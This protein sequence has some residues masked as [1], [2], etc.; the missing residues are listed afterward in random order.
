MATFKGL[1]FSVDNV[2]GATF[3]LILGGI[4]AS[5]DVTTSTGTVETLFTEVNRLDEAIYVGIKTGTKP[6]AID[7]TF[8]S[9]NGEID[10]QKLSHI[11]RSLFNNNK[12]VKLRILQTDLN[13]ITY[14]GVFEECNPRA[15][16]NGIFGI[17]CKFQLLSNYAYEGKKTKALGNTFYNSSD[18]PNGLKPIIEFTMSASGGD[19]SIVNQT[20]G[21]EFKFTGLTGGE[22]ITVDCESQIITS[23]L[24]LRRLK[25]FNKGWMRFEKGLNKLTI[26]SNA[27]TVNVTYENKRSVGW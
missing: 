3:G 10:R 7:V 6:E 2:A 17:E 20:N 5:G 15:L 9:L 23:S 11:K 26:S 8:V 27:K 24:D 25:N 18:A 21:I 14:K 4:G 22:K 1:Q 12:P 13:T 19:F 16:G